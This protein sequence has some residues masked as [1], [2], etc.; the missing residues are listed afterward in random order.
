MSC[1]AACMLISNKQT[2][3]NQVLSVLLSWLCLLEV[4]IVVVEEVFGL[5]T[6]GVVPLVR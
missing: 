6:F 3:L 1:T 2:L 5:D 4:L